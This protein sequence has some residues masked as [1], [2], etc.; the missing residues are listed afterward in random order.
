MELKTDK[1]LKKKKLPTKATTRTLDL[2][3]KKKEKRHK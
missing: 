3:K 2:F 1:Q